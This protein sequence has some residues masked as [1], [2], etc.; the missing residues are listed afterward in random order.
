M[1]LAIES[2][3]IS[4]IFIKPLVAMT[5]LFDPPVQAPDGAA[6]AAIRLR[7]QDNARIGAQKANG[8]EEIDRGV[9]RLFSN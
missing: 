2:K 4:L 7:Y 1:I 3:G 5:S 9:I 6:S 8:T